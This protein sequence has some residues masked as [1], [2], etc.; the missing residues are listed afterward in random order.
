L[1]IVP[2]RDETNMMTQVRNEFKITMFYF[3][4]FETL[5]A[6]ETQSTTMQLKTLT[7]TIQ[8]WSRGLFKYFELSTANFILIYIGKIVKTITTTW[9]ACSQKYY[10]KCSHGSVGGALVFEVAKKN[11]QFFLPFCRGANLRWTR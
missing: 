5:A 1:N 6:C 10:S 2:I 3:L 4:T 9:R 7:K 8:N 11:T